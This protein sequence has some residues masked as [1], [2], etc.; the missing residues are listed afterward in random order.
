MFD[1]LW[2]NALYT[3]HVG[4]GGSANQI[5]SRGL[6]QRLWSLAAGEPNSP[7]SYSS[8]Y[9]WGDDFMNFM[10]VASGTAVIGQP[11]EG[12]YYGVYTTSG[13]TITPV[14]NALD[15][16]GVMRI[17]N[18]GAT[19]FEATVT[20]GNNVGTFCCINDAAIAT[21]APPKRL[22]FETRIRYSAPTGALLNPQGTFFV[23][24]SDAACAGAA[25]ALTTAAQP[26]L[27]TTKNFL[28]F[29]VKQTS[30]TATALYFTYQAASQAVVNVQLATWAVGLVNTSVTNTVGVSGTNYSTLASADW[31]KLGFAYNPTANSD[32]AANPQKL[33]VYINDV[34]QPGAA[35]YGATLQGATFPGGSGANVPLAALIATKGS[36]TATPV[37]ANL[38]VDWMT[39]WQGAV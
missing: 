5:A 14:S 29:T 4:G 26:L 10:T 15:M 17:T 30:G 19:S 3:P 9:Q 35:V 7:D 8:A 21:A 11:F 2:A 23:G 27:V 6:S 32:T 34:E 25:A 16:G 12:G 13:P 28:G 24:L 22:I 1:T 36:S 37:A 38:D 39:V 18:T 33:K 31:V 20:T